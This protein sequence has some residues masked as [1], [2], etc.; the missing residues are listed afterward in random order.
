M[1]YHFSTCRRLSLLED[2]W[3]IIRWLVS[4]FAVQF[5]S[6]QLSGRGDNT[7][8]GLVSSGCCSLFP[9]ADAALGIYCDWSLQSRQHEYFHYRLLLVIVASLCRLDRFLLPCLS[10][11]LHGQESHLTSHVNTDDDRYRSSFEQCQG[12][13][14]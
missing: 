5:S 10:V 11:L 3:N 4:V 8:V 6:V 9:Q 1:C 2:D 12:H 13:D 7:V 14:R